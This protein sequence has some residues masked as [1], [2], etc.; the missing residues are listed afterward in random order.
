MGP[1]VAP[2]GGARAGEEKACFPGSLSHTPCFS[3]KTSGVWLSDE[4][5]L[6]FRLGNFVSGLTLSERKRKAASLAQARG[7]PRRR[8]RRGL[9]LPPRPASG[10][11]FVSDRISVC[12]LGGV[13]FWQIIDI[14]QRSQTLLD[15]GMSVRSANPGGGGGG[16]PAPL[17]VFNTS[18]GISNV[19]VPRDASSVR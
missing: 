5:R 15:D 7:V 18:G 10:E 14:P 3:P 9:L 19:S 17:S 13:C 1:P 11:R 2:P 16:V 12:R 6:G 8:N 4:F